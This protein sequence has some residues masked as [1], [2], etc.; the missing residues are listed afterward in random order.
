MRPTAVVLALLVVSGCAAS[1]KPLASD[2]VALPT[3]PRI[4]SPEACAG[5]GVSASLR[6][7]ATDPRLAWLVDKVGRRIEVTWPPDYRARFN[8]KLEVLDAD[9]VVMLREG[10]AVSGACVTSDPLVLHLESPFR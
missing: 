5:I 4:E 8:P 7:D 3:D 9:G 2:E 10:D 6:G 1:P